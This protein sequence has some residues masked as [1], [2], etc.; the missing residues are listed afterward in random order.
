MTLSVMVMK[1]VLALLISEGLA[2][3]L[4]VR[5]AREKETR[6]SYRTRNGD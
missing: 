1:I 3:R 2:G 4:R 5:L 6:I